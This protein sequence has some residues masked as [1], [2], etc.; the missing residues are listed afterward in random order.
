MSRQG[1]VSQNPKQRYANTHF[2]FENR[3]MSLLFISPYQLVLALSLETSSLIQLPLLPVSWSKIN[4][5]SFPPVVMDLQVSMAFLGMWYSQTS[6]AQY[7]GNI[8]ISLGPADLTLDVL[9]PPISTTVPTIVNNAFA[10]GLIAAD[11]ISFAF[12]S[13][14]TISAT[15]LNG[16]LTWGISV[17]NVS[18]FNQLTQKKGGTSSDNSTGTISF[19]YV[20]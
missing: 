12:Q 8:T 4:L 20:S 11:E 2:L 6:M 16:V 10:Q 17:L 9:S 7:V 19:R 13:A 3:L 15:P 14:T 5:L 1:R 18:S